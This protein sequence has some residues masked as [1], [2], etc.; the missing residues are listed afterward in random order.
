MFFLASQALSF[1]HT[2][3][4]SKNI[5]DTTFKGYLRY[6]TIT[7]PNVSSEAQIKKFFISQKN[8]VLFSRYSSFY[9]SNHPMIYQICDVTMR[10]TLKSCS[11]PIHWLGEIKNSH[12]T[13]T[14]RNFFCVLSVCVKK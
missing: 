11:F 3:Q 7:S 6:K 9:I 13:P 14:G 2:K 10:P 5:V 4:T 1:R 8:Y 12:K